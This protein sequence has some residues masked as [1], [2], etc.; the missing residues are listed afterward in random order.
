MLYSIYQILSYCIL[1]H[2]LKYTDFT[3]QRTISYHCRS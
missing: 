2:G 3:H 1:L